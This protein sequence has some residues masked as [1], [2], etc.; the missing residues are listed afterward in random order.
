MTFDMTL[1]RKIKQLRTQR[2]ISQ[3]KLAEELHVSRSAVAKWETDG[4]IPEL[5]NLLHLANIFGVSLDELTGNV[6]QTPKEP[7]YT[8]EFSSIYDF[9]KQLYDIELTGW[10]DGAYDVS[11]VEEDQ[12]FLF[13]RKTVQ[14]KS[15]YGM[16]GKRYI[17]SLSPVKGTVNPQIPAPKI[18]RSY[19]CA[20]PVAIELTKKEGLIRGFFDFRDDDYRNV[21]INTFD[22]QVLHLQFGRTLDIHEITKVEELTDQT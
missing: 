6:E 5:D 4:G 21:I 2:A 7:E 13:Y 17:T 12:D 9:G 22:E 3:E 20:R 11:V 15:V 18:D 14:K 10:N 16:I 8:R 19:F 1:G